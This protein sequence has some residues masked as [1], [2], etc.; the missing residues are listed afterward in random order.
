MKNIV[1]L[2]SALLLLA[3]AA[4]ASFSCLHPQQ[5]DDANDTCEENGKYVDAGIDC[6][7]QLEDLI[8][9][10]KSQTAQK[11]ERSNRRHLGDGKNRQSSAFQGTSADYKIADKALN[12]LV[13]SAKQ[14][15]R[16]VSAYL[17]NIYFPEEFDAPEEI[18]GDGI[19][20]LNSSP[21]YAE[22]RDML[23]A[24]LSDIDRHIADLE[25]AAADARTLNK[26]SVGRTDK[27]GQTEGQQ[28]PAVRGPASGAPVKVRKKKKRDS[29]ISGTERTRKP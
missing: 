23:R 10:T 13:R 19:E 5:L 1:W 7:D 26:Q 14:A 21:C 28:G 4:E 15:K 22:P 17:D 18:I 6:L 16:H 25:R 12:G 3:P 29:D 24:M 8:E 9:K 2:A 11:L 27:L 20:Y